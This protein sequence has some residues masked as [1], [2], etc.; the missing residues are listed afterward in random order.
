VPASSLT[1]VIVS[2]GHIAHVK[3]KNK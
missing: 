1:V 2:Y 3:Q